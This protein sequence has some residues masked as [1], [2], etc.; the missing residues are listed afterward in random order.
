MVKVAAD[1]LHFPLPHL[2]WVQG[3]LSWE[4]AGGSPAS[5]S[6]ARA[7]G[8]ATGLSSGAP[9]KAGGP[10][11]LQACICAGKKRLTARARRGDAQGLQSGPDG[12]DNRGPQCG[13]RGDFSLLLLLATL[14][15]LE[16]KTDASLLRIIGVTDSGPSRHP[17]LPSMSQGQGCSVGPRA[18]GDPDKQG[19]CTQHRTGNDW[20][21]LPSEFFKNVG[22]QAMIPFPLCPPHGPGGSKV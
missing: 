22:S 17:F 12:Q 10:N 2:W 6:Q 5:P 13:A 16:R 4:R 3:P 14:P 9:G 7:K 19:V 18:S 20:V 21:L 11:H 15:N 1:L 8:P